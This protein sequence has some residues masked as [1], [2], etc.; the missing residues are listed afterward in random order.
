[1]VSLQQFV[2][3]KRNAVEETKQVEINFNDKI[4]Q[5]HA[6]K[7]RAEVLDSAASKS[8]LSTKMVAT[9]NSPTP[10]T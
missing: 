2:A 3:L 9:A 1:M 6:E 10:K 8:M 7:I 4:K 5:K